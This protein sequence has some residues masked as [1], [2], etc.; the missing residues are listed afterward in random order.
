MPL[1]ETIVVDNT[2]HASDHN[3]VH[4]LVGGLPTNLTAGSIAYGSTHTGWHQSIHTG[5]NT[6]SLPSYPGSPGLPGSFTTVTAPASIQ[7]AINA[8][9]AGANIKLV[10]NWTGSNRVSSS[11]VPKANMTIFA[12]TKGAAV[13]EGAPAVDRIFDGTNITG[14]RLENLNVY[15]SDGNGLRLG[16]NW[17]LRGCEVYNCLTTGISAVQAKGFLVEDCYVHNNGSTAQLGNNA[18]GFKIIRA[19]NVFDNSS[20]GPGGVVRY[21]KFW[22]NVGNGLWWDVDSGNATLDTLNDPA[23]P[24]SG[25]TTHAPN[26]AYANDVRNN[27][28]RGIFFEVSRG[29]CIIRWNYTAGNATDQ[30]AGTGNAAQIG[31]SASKNVL[32]EYNSIGTG[33]NKDIHVG[34]I[35]RDPPRPWEPGYYH[36]TNVTIRR[37]F[38]NGGSITTSTSGGA[39]TPSPTS[40]DNPPP[41][42]PTSS[43][44]TGHLTHH[45]SS[46]RWANTREENPTWP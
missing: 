32:I 43:L 20:L 44:S 11:I 5:V 16:P 15:G 24:T 40:S 36:S 22:N 35:T 34:N 33:G 37:N 2:A 23:T 31:V 8:A 30:A 3:I 13:V 17:V 26:V 9:S 46:H 10:G 38:M 25:L 1:R 7:S 27:T 45:N 4:A 41:A 29:P 18:S 12:A 28:R 21:S 39:P 42:L 14:V 6:F 19:G